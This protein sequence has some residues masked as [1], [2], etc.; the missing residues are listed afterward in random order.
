MNMDYFNYSTVLV[1]N[2]L[3]AVIL[4]VYKHTV[5]L[6]LPQTHS[7]IE[8]NFRNLDIANTSGSYCESKTV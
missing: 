5:D 4:I 2:I 1:N 3:I 6:I 8:S 7:N